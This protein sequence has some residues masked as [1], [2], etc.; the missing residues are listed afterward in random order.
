MTILCF[1]PCALFQLDK[2]GMGEKVN[3]GNVYAE[4][5]EVRG[6]SGE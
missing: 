5:A 1:Y 3:A 6:I 4:W 2:E